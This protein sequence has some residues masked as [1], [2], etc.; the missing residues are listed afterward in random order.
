[1]LGGRLDGD[2]DHPP[3]RGAGERGERDVRGLPRD[4]SAYLAAELFHSCFTHP[5]AEAGG[6]GAGT[7]FAVDT[8]FDGRGRTMRGVVA[9]A[10]P[11]RNLVDRSADRGAVTQFLSTGRHGIIGAPAHRVRAGRSMA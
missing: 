4:A 8:R 9:E 3:N 6:Y 7:A 2:I 11:G 1:M 10:D 5:T